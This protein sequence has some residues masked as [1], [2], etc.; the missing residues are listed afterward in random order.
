VSSLEKILNNLSIFGAEAVGDEQY[1]V[2]IA[3][4]IKRLPK[5]VGEKVLKEVNFIVAEGVDGTGF[6]MNI[7]SRSNGMLIH[8]RAQLVFK[9]FNRDID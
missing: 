6:N 5:D 2:L 4:T 9:F 7:F 3:K 8:E 1:K